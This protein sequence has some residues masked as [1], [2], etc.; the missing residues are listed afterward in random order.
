MNNGIVKV[1]IVLAATAALSGC[2]STATQQ[3]ILS[4]AD[5]QTTI[6]VTVRT[7]EPV[8]IQDSLLA[9]RD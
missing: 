7:L 9:A 6:H 1:I 5:A 8:A 4:A 3:P 2:G